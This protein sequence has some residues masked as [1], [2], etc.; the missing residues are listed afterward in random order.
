M[1]TKIVS[2]S[3]LMD[4]VDELIETAKK[5]IKKEKTITHGT[6]P[7]DI[8]SDDWINEQVEWVKPAFKKFLEPDPAVFD[9]LSSDMRKVADTFGWN[10]GSRDQRLGHIKDARDNLSDFKGAFVKDLRDWLRP[11]D[12]SVCGNTGKVAH[13]LDKNAHGLRE[14]YAHGRKQALKI[15][16]QA[17]EAYDSLTDCKGSGIA[18]L[19]AILTVGTS[20][21]TPLLPS[22]K[23]VEVAAAAVSE[24]LSEAS[25]LTEDEDVP[26]GGDSVDEVADNLRD[27]LKKARKSIENGEKGVRNALRD[28]YDSV[29]G[30]MDGNSNVPVNLPFPKVWDA[31]DPTD[32]IKPE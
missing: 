24:G 28:T 26:L 6:F 25:D 19:L 30:A 4:A 21:L 16:K 5:K 14:T 23:G 29:S 31:D 15:A 12:E 11:L 32:G 18:I 9:G 10:N 20:L 22:N 3:E 27:A 7:P 17:N 1:A 8:P 2:E 13:M